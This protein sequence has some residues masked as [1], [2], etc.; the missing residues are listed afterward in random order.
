MERGRRLVVCGASV[1][2]YWCT[3]ALGQGGG[4]WFLPT[5]GQDI[6]GVESVRVAEAGA[7]EMPVAAKRLLHA[8][9]GLTEAERREVR[10]HP[11]RFPH[12][13]FMRLMP[14][15]RVHGWYAHAFAVPPSLRGLDVLVELGLID[16]ADEISPSSESTTIPAYGCQD[17]SMTCRTSWP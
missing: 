16:D 6:R 3:L 15:R 4:W 12:R 11:V 13:D 14:G 8:S 2:V 17:G 5:Y 1:W 10:W 7:P 9:G